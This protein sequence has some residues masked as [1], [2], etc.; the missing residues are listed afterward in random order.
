MAEDLEQLKRRFPLLDYLR[1][2]NW[3]ARRT[4]APAEFV[5]LC[6][7]H[8]ETRPSFYV[9]AHK[10]LFYCHGCGYGGDLIRFVELSQGLSFRQSVAYLQQSIPPADHGGVLE[11]AVAFYQL[12]LHRHA[13][14]V[15]YLEHRGL[16]DPDLIEQLG[17]GYAPG[18]PSGRPRLFVRSAVADRADQQPGPRRLLPAGHFSASSAR[19]A[20][21]TSTAAVSATPSRTGSC[22][23]PRE[24]CL[25]GTP[26]AGTPS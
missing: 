9:N 11:S 17:I 16:R 1:R 10:N 4:A 6:P 13:E 19:P 12:Q 14:A 3:T 23:I 22:R 8:R 7:L 2:S 15:Q 18:T 24:V 20:S 5:G 25:R 21:S 26:S